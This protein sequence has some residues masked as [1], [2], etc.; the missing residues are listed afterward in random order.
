LRQTHDATIAEVHDRKQALHDVEGAL[1]HLE[2][3]IAERYRV[4]LAAECG[5]YHLR[6][7]SGEA[8]EAHVRELKS[9]I[10]RMGEINLMAIE[11]CAE[12][13]RRNAFLLAQKADLESAL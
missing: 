1:V 7:L 10:E 11:E 4:A 8:E 2:E 12:L 5:D 6:P 13:E 3:A 9:L